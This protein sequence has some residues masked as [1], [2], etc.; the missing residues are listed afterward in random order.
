MPKCYPVQVDDKIVCYAPKKYAK[1][2]SQCIYQMRG[3][4]SDGFTEPTITILDLTDPVTFS[5]SDASPPNP[6]S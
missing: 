3:F 2:V 5:S 1:F 4:F 6:D